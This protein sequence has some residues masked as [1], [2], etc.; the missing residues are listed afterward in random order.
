M[1][2]IVGCL[3]R[4]LNHKL[5]N[6][7]LL[8]FQI[9][10]CKCYIN[11]GSALSSQAS[12]QGLL[13]WIK[14]KEVKNPNWQEAN[15]LA[16]YKRSRGVEPRTTLNNS[17]WWSERDLKSVS[18]EF[19]SGTLTTRPRCLPCLA[20]YVKKLYLSACR[21]FGTIIFPL[22]TNQIIAFWRAFT[23]KDQ[24]IALR[25]STGIFCCG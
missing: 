9:P 22:W 10:N 17:S 5:G 12:S 16:T 24:V 15:H 20:D 19:K 7:T 8:F 23:A 25:L 18:P 13:F 4:R 21:T 2:I 3:R 11:S 14:L 1:K 6:F